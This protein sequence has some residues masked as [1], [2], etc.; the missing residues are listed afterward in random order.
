LPSLNDS[1]TGICVS[2]C[3]QGYYINGSVC[4]SCTVGCLS[5]LSSGFCLVYLN[6]S[7]STS[8]LWNKYIALWVILIILG[9]LLLTGV[10][11]KLVFSRKTEAD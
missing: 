5:C 3:P 11:W 7:N 8:T 10:I 6:Q 2:A 4:F 9:I 1:T